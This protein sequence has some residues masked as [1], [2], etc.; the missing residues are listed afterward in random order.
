METDIDYSNGT[1][2]V[3][4]V[5]CWLGCFTEVHEEM[6][7]REC[8]PFPGFCPTD[9]PLAWLAIM[10]ARGCSDEPHKIFETINYTGILEI[11]PRTY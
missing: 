11:G 4:K 6:R 5:C 3:H 7:L 1:I 8:E 10:I 2:D 9:F